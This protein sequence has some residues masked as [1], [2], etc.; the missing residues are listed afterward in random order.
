M[1]RRSC[2]PA[3]AFAAGCFLHSTPSARADVVTLLPGADATLVEVAPGNSLGGADFFNA[4]TAGANGLRNRALMSFAL[5]G[6]IPPGSI[7]TSVSLTLEVTRFP[8]PGAQ[9]SLFFLRRMLQS[10]GEG[11]QVP[12][13]GPGL[14][15]PALPGDATWLSRFAGG[16][17]WAAPGGLAGVDFVDAPSAGA[18]L[19][20]GDPLNFE[21]SPQLVA[22]VQYWVDNPSENFGWILMTE[23][24]SVQKSA[25]SFASRESGFGPMLVIEFTPVPEPSALALLALALGGAFFARRRC[26]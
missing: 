26:R 22:D 2:L 24:E 15:A 6:A 16:P 11:A 10:W 12:E 9:S 20:A 14:G 13:G 19:S 25:R 18:F 5:G 4:G 3:L 7:I 23:D 17:A 21:T 1:T 8:D